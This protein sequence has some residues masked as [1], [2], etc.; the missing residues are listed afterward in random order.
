VSPK[1]RRSGGAEIIVVSGLPRSGTSLMMS[2]LGAGGIELLTD[3]V[4]QA[5]VDNPRGYFELEPVKALATDNTWL[6][7]AR[8]KAIKVISALLEHLPRDERYKVV[9]MR[10]E[11]DEVLESQAR[12]LERRTAT[13]AARDAELRAEFAAHIAAT[14]RSLRGDPAF[15]VHPVSYS[16]L[17]DEPAIELARVARFL[18]RELDEVAMRRCIDP[19]LRR[20]RGGSEILEVP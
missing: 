20:N 19:A 3:G 15:D 5:D 6:G 18:G 2:L 9:F 10:R 4:R 13:R 11:L 12:M 1:L 17:L 14:E 16:A 7:S 8:G